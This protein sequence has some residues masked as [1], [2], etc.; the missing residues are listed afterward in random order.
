MRPSP[1]TAIGVVVVTEMAEL[2]R[3][4]AMRRYELG[5][6]QTDFD[7]AAGWADGYAAKVEAGY[8]TYGKNSLPIALQALGVRLEVRLRPDPTLK[9]VEPL[10]PEMTN[11]IRAPRGPR[12]RL[13]TPIVP[14]HD[15]EPV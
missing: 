7:A 3:L 13:V 2:T 6:S 8:R 11:R 9:V 12:P 15:P 1:D 4:L 5:L 14:S 10:H